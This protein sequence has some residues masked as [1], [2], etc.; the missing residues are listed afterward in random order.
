MGQLS[1]LSDPLVGSQLLEVR[2]KPRDGM[3]SPGSR[4]RSQ[5]QAFAHDLQQASNRLDARRDR[6]P[7]D[8][9]DLG[10]TRSRSAG[11]RTLIEAV[12]PS[13]LPD[14]SASVHPQRF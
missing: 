14:D 6:A 12:A 4:R 8:A 5:L 11:Q 3:V 1:S 9:A 2:P 13:N 10:L 7:L